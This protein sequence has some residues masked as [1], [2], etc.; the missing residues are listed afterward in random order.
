MALPRNIPYSGLQWINDLENTMEYL[1]FLSLGIAIASV[2]LRCY[3][4]MKE[5]AAL[6]SQA[7]QHLSSHAQRVQ[8]KMIARRFLRYHRGLA[9]A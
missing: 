7:E 6:P 5:K 2:G 4:S 9:H 8:E 3:F 1:G